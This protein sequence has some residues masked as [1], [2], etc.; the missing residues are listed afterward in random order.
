MIDS[1]EI[2]GFKSH[3]TQKVELGLVNVFIGPNGSGK[4]NLLEAVG[5]MGAAAW[6]L[7]E[8]QALLYRGVRPGVERLYKS[9]FKGTISPQKIDLFAQSNKASYKAGLYIPAGSSDSS[10]AY[11]TESVYVGSTKISGYSPRSTSRMP[12]SR[13]K[14]ALERQSWSAKSPAADLLDQLS[15]YCIYS[16]TTQTLRNLIQDPQNREPVGLSGGR[17]AEA[18]QEL[19]D[20]KHPLAKEVFNDIFGM[21][22]WAS[23]FGAKMPGQIPLSRS[24][25]AS[26]YILGFKDKY[27]REGQNWLSGYD[28]SEGA[29]YL[30]FTAVLLLHPKSPRFF[31]IDNAD[32]GL[33]PRLARRLF[34]CICDWT[35]AAEQ[36][37]QILLTTHNPLVLDGLKLQDEN[38]RLFTVDRDTKGR[39]IVKR[40]TVDEKLLKLAKEK[41]LPLSRLWVMGLLGGVPNV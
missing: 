21:I 31:A 11:K 6:G 14:A 5:L 25:S 3:A 2:T 20:G 10:W 27:L 12:A 41:D 7:V 23:S 1:I 9:G 30:L 34:E 28:A 39:S 33:N 36:P 13:G 40:V 4:S 8:D 38:I 17:L 37:R 19:I 35:L 18:V 29:L 15:G 22:G 26:G 32:H 24:V 16:P